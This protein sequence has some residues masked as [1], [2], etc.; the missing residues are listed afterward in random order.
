MI[1]KSSITMYI[2]TFWSHDPHRDRAIKY[3]NFEPNL[4]VHFCLNP[5]PHV[6]MC[7]LLL[8]PSPTLADVFYG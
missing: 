3:L 1:L 2:H 5:L 6:R 7:P 4:D 8:E